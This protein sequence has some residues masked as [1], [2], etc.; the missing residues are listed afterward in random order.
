V[1]AGG[2]GRLLL[3]RTGHTVPSPSASL[4]VAMTTISE[5]NDLTQVRELLLEYSSS[6]GVDLSFQDFDHELATLETYYEVIRIARAGENVAGCIALRR[7]N[8]ETCEMKRLYVRP[9]FRGQDLGR[10]LAMAII[11]EARSRGYMRMRLDTMPMMSS[12]IAL[13]ESLGFRDI[14]PYRFNPVAGTRFMELEL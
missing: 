6:L 8:A 10:A 1:W 9:A 5:A 14:A 13:Y 12:A 11:A 4:R 2:A 3:S 7:I